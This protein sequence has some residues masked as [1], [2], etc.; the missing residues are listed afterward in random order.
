MNSFVYIQYTQL[1]LTTN[2]GVLNSL[3]GIIATIQFCSVDTYYKGVK[4][5]STEVK[6]TSKIKVGEKVKSEELEY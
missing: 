2:S 3:L 6:L 4:T 1:P 5:A